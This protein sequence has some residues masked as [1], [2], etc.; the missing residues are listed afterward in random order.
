MKLGI[1]DLDLN[2][3]RVL[4][5]VDFNVPLDGDTITDDARIRKAVPSIQHVIDHGGKLVLMSHLGRPK[6]QVKDDCRLAPCAKRLSELIG[7]HVQMATDCIG[8]EV[9]ALVEAMQPGE[10]VLLENLRFHPEEEANDSEFA[11]ALAKLGDVYVSDAFGAVHRAHASIEGVTHHL[12]AAAGFLLQKEIEYLGGALADPKRP[13]LTILGG[14]KVKDKIPVIENLLT[15]VD[16]LLIGGGMAYTF[17]KAQGA[18]IGSSKCDEEHLEFVKEMLARAQTK[19]VDMLLPVDHVVAD[20]FNPDGFEPWSQVQITNGV[21]IEDGWLGLDIGPRSAE[22]FA[23][24]VKAAGTVVWNGPAGVFEQEAYRAGTRT[25]ADALAESA[26]VTIVG[27]GDTAAAVSMFGL[28]DKMSHVSTGG[29]ASLELLE[30]KALPGIE[31]LRD[32]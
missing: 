26:A 3:K 8:P 16:A 15:K 19:G 27:G 2:G 9:E 11:K 1:Q 7:K 13:F 6:G 23:D 4:M 28:E 10:V 22:L 5:R 32:K 29:G 20:K 18:R 25:V 21:D 31:A 17:L 14:A 24:K 30:G 12:K